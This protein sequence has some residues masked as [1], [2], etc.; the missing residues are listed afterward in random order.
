L[1]KDARAD[2]KPEHLFCYCVEDFMTVSPGKYAPRMTFVGSER[3]NRL[4]IEPWAT[5]FI[6]Q[7]GER[8]SIEFPLEDE[9]GALRDEYCIFEVTEHS[10]VLYPWIGSSYQIFRDGIEQ[11]P[12]SY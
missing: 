4:I 5:E 2:E 1:N 12:E 3:L 6:L 8:I 10:V 7:I 11:L 9:A